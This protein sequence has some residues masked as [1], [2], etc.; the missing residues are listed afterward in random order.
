MPHEQSL[1]DYVDIGR[2]F[3]YFFL[4]KLMFARYSWSYVIFPDGFG[5]LDETFEIL[6]LMQTGKTR[7]TP[8]V[9]AGSY[10]W[11]GLIEWM[12]SDLL[13]PSRV[14]SAD[15]ELVRVADEPD[16]I[17]ALATAGLPN[18]PAAPA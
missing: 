7:P 12:R 1:N 4:R 3:H 17:V 11:G 13:E 14:S 15:F 18:L 2:E 9:L 8:I 6:T 10:F 5:T 16:E